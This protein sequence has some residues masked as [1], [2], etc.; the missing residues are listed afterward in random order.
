MADVPAS[1]VRMAY[2]PAA[3]VQ[4]RAIGV[5]AGGTLV[6]VADPGFLSVLTQGQIAATQSLVSGVGI[7]PNDVSAAA[8]NTAV[9][10]AAILTGRCAIGSK[11]GVCYI[12]D[13][14]MHDSNCFISIGQGTEIRSAGPTRFSMISSANA[15]WSGSGMPGVAII[16]AS[17]AT[18]IGTGTIRQATT[19][20]RL[21]YTAPGD[22]EGGGVDVSAAASGAARFELASANGKK[23]YVAAVVAALSGASS[24]SVRVGAT[25]GA[26]P[27]TYTNTSNTTTVTEAGHD[28]QP[29]DAVIL[30]GSG[31]AA[32]VFVETSVL[33]TSWTFTD[34]RGNSS[35]S[36]EAF[37]RVNLQIT[38]R[39][40]IN[41]YSAGG[42]ANRSTQDK[43]TINLYGLSHWKID[44]ILLRDG[45]KYGIMGQC[46]SNY[47]IDVRGFSD[48]ATTSTA[49]VQINGKAR[50]GRIRCSGKS[51][52]TAIALIAG[53]YP[54]QTLLFPNDE[55]GLD[56]DDTE[57]VGSDGS[58]SNFDG[59]RL[60]GA[61][62][63]WHRNTRIYNL[64]HN[65]R[66]T[67]SQIIGVIVDASIYLG[68]ETN[69]EGLLIDGVFPSKVGTNDCV[70][71]R[72]QFAGAIKS[73]GVLI[74]RVELGYAAEANGS[75]AI[76]LFGGNVRDITVEDCYH[77]AP[78]WQGNLICT[79]GSA[80]GT[81][82][83]LTIR[84]NHLR[85]DNALKNTA[86]GSNLLIMNNANITYEQ[87]IVDNGTILDVSAGGTKSGVVS[88][89]AGVAKSLSFSNIRVKDAL[90]LCYINAANLGLKITANNILLDYTSSGYCFRLDVPVG[91]VSL[92]NIRSATSTLV[93]LVRIGFSSSVMKVRSNGGMPATPSSGFH[94]NLAAG[95]ANSPDVNGADLVCDITKLAAVTGNLVKASSTS[96]VVMYDGA[97]WTAIA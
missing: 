6:A 51:T 81:I 31:L 52:D 47:D 14:L 34:S 35:G 60:A 49:T 41:F 54:T 69:I 46:I 57:I 71:V 53:D 72:L 27:V 12:S 95:T 4:I 21:F 96:K 26:K 44:G 62:G 8:A 74:R 59:V 73:S 5:G 29:G 18:A 67:T 93:D 30:F 11:L 84:N 33:G 83:C 22:V 19:P 80:V 32:N 88:I 17:D 90:N 9:M 91:E 20:A 40:T 43:N 25:S 77:R 13:T 48:T 15:V 86:W 75:G 66:S 28:R 97:A 76:S 87:V 94:V 55:G 78:S 58:D 65:V 37:G 89:Y 68:T 24:A 38:G 70:I 50:H 92:G 79:N 56:F 85:I 16:C 63:V 3:A 10:Q 23:L 7:A 39:G 36:G 45:L 2:V 1:G 61:A 64:R 42:V 82:D